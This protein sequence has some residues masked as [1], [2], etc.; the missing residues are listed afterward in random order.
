[1]WSL[2][3]VYHVTPPVN[4]L[5]SADAVNK[6][7]EQQIARDMDI[8]CLKHM[9]FKSISSVSDQQIPAEQS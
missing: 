7:Y 1:M 6:S 5:Q 4:L 3:Q 8:S 2:H 9:M